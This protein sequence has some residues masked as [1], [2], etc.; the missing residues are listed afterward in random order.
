MLLARRQT[1]SGKTECFL[2]P[3]LDACAQHAG[4]PGFNAI[5]I[6]PMNA[7]ATDQAKRFARAICADTALRGRVRAGLFIGGE[8][9]IVEVFVLRNKGFANHPP[10][11]D[12]S[13]RLPLVR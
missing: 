2:Y 6:Y 7:L 11:T 4:E 12:R 3:I 1:G 13:Q 9:D 5:V 8:G 10:H